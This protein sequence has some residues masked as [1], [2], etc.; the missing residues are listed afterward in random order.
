M[1]MKNEKG[2]SLI[3]YGILAG[4]ISVLS[5]GTVLTT[6]GEVSDMFDGVNTTLSSTLGGEAVA[7]ATPLP[8]DAE[9]YNAA[10]IGTV[11]QGGWIG[12]EGMLIVD[13]TMIKGAGGS[14]WGGNDSFAIT[15]GDGTFTFTQDGSDIFTGQVTDIQ[16]LFGATTFNGD[17]SYWNVSNVEDMSWA[18]YLTPF[19]GDISSWNTSKVTTMNSTFFDA[20][21]FNQDI[22]DWDT[23]NVTD[24][25]DMFSMAT[26]FNGDISSWNTSS[27]ENMY[28][29]LMSAE[30][31]NQDLSSWDVSSVTNYTSFDSGTTAWILPK[32]VFP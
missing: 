3:E 19:N 20:A 13:T 18:F 1:K 25:G 9:C 30:D 17:I 15:T 6:G 21:S 31:F 12:C 27:V 28:A 26:A 32:P 24:M 10:N 7:D 2:A 4:L 22:G 16:G 23:S 14:T 11:G 5:I 8:T 29:M